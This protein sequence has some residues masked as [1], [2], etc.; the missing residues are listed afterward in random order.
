MR[1]CSHPGEAKRLA[2]RL[3]REIRKDWYGDVRLIVMRILLSRKFDNTELRRRLVATRPHELREGNTWGDLF[4]G[5]DRATGHG[6]NHLG[7]MLM[8]LREELFGLAPEEGD[9]R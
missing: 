2:R 7:R 4:W 9:E 6:E 1:R 5:V 8:E 3:S